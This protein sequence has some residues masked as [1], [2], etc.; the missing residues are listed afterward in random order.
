MFG[1][2]VWGC[3]G[4]IFGGIW[5]YFGDRSC[6]PGF[7]IPSFGGGRGPADFHLIFCEGEMF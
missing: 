4:G 2:G 5:M 7:C 3:V 1:G 6:G